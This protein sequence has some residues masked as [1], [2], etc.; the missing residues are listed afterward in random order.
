MRIVVDAI[1]SIIK[2]PITIKFPF[3]DSPVPE[4][5]R[6]KVVHYPDRCIYC[7]SCVRNCPAGAIKFLRKEKAFKIDIGRCIFCGQ[8]EEFCP[9]NAIV[10]TKK[11]KLHTRTRES[12]I[13][14]SRKVSRGRVPREKGR[15]KKEK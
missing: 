7:L 6:G 3:Q 9:V 13:T 10:L 8:C 2:G 1:K 11:Y 5:Y 12:L 14:I 4:R 15:Q